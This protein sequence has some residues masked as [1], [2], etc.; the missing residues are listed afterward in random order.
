MVDHAGSEY[1]FIS[2]AIAEAAV[3][4]FDNLL[5][6]KQIARASTSVLGGKSRGKH[7]AC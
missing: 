1:T 2:F 5:T 7:F 4:D 6:A 3:H